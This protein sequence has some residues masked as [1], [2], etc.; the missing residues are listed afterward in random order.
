MR[1]PKCQYISFDNGDSCRNCGYQ[2]SLSPPP[3][4]PLDLPIQTGSEP[5]GPLADLR[6]D[7]P[8]FRGT[9][10]PDETPLVSASSTPRAPLGVRRTAPA[11][12]KPA[13][14]RALA[15]RHLE[16]MEEPELDL[17][18]EE[19]PRPALVVPPDPVAVDDE[20][21]PRGVE[22]AAAGPRLAA[23]LI[24]LVVLGG[25]DAVV[26]HYTLK[27]AGLEYSELSVLPLAPFAAFLLL[28]NGG[29]AV[30]FTAAGGQSIGKM[31]AGVRVVRSDPDA[32]SDRVTVGQAVLRSIGYLL[33]ALPAGLGF[34]PALVGRDRRAL[35]D[36]LAGT[37]VIKA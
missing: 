25:I 16:E 14:S 37:R 31:L 7:L 28:L 1:C 21:G 6:L 10:T 13:P 35:H 33:S 11:I 4:E 9:R 30:A 29:Y 3:A 26:L 5:E 20:P 18:P 24:D 23:A 27:T 17:Q 19:P 36:R 2:F 8:L 32:W 22:A 12:A 34:L 15:R